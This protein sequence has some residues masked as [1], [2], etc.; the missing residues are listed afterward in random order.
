MGTDSEGRD[1]LSAIT[2][3]A[4]VA[5]VKI[6]GICGPEPASVTAMELRC[7][8][9]SVGNNWESQLASARSVDIGHRLCDARDLIV[10]T[11]NRPLSVNSV[12]SVSQ[13]RNFKKR[14]LGFPAY[15]PGWRGGLVR[16]E[17]NHAPSLPPLASIPL[18]TPSPVADESPAAASIAAGRSPARRLRPLLSS[19]APRTAGASNRSAPAPTR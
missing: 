14:Q 7:A 11:S 1:L 4:G 13:Y 8:G 6:C 10:S 18:T 5:S 16:D 12:R 9:A 2:A 17:R 3:P 19:Y 15:A